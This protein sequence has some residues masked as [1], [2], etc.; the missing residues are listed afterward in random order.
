MA[1]SSSTSKGSSSSRPSKTP[2]TNGNGKASPALIGIIVG[3]VVLAILLLAAALFLWRRSVAR[4]RARMALNPAFEKNAHKFQP[5]TPAPGR[6]SQDAED[7]WHSDAAGLIH[8]A[9]PVHGHAGKPSIGG[10]PSF[11]QSGYAPVSGAAPAH[12]VDTG[13]AGAQAHGAA[14]DYYQQGPSVPQAPHG[15]P[16]PQ[17]FEP[18]RAPQA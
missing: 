17:K 1:D 5:V 4:K 16:G 2:L 8:N 12:E 15:S 3:A 18:Y 6:T 14:E 10:M 9:A 11:G 7:P 13:Y